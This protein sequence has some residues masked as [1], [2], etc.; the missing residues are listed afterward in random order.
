LNGGLTVLT[1]E[2]IREAVQTIAPR[3][4][5]DRVYLFGSYARGDATEESDV[6]FRVVGGNIRSLFDLG[7]L[8]VDFEDVLCKRIDFVLSNNMTEKFYNLIKDEEAL[9]YAKV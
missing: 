9:I 8:Y 7:G 6:D 1:Q 3:Y 4:G 5:I 2:K